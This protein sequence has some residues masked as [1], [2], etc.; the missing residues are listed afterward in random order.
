MEKSLEGSG[1]GWWMP[2]LL[3]G[4]LPISLFAWVSVWTLQTNTWDLLRIAQQPG[5]W[6]AQPFLA[7]TR[8]QVQRLNQKEK[9]NIQRIT[10]GN[11]GHARD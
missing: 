8:R 1:Q 6:K 3:S 9:S 7:S 2:S 11:I 10:P 4:V 5:S